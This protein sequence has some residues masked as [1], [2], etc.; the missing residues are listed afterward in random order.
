[1]KS[2]LSENIGNGFWSSNSAL[3]PYFPAAPA[4]SK[5][6]PGVSLHCVRAVGGGGPAAGLQVSLRTLQLQ[7]R[8]GR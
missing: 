7:R 1:M 6:G 5:T 4:L 2:Y 3:P 8:Q